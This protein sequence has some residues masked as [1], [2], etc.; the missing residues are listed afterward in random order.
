MDIVAFTHDSTVSYRIPK[1]L[2]QLGKLPVG[3]ESRSRRP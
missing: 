2:H 3:L 1:H